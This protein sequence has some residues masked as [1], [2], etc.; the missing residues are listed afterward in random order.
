MET[1]RLFIIC[2]ACYVYP[3][4]QI[5]RINEVISSRTGGAPFCRCVHC[6]LD[7]ETQPIAVTKAYWQHKRSAIRY[8]LILKSEKSYTVINFR[9]SSERPMI[10]C[11]D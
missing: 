4:L 8:G 2:V 9:F 3:T 6:V 1:R 11:P 5:L 10:G 7:K